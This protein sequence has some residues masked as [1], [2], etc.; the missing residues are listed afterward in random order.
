MVS[1]TSAS[2][3]REQKMR[4]QKEEI[5]IHQPTPTACTHATR[6]GEDGCMT[7][8]INPRYRSDQFWM[9]TDEEEGKGRAGGKAR[10]TRWAIVQSQTRHTWHLG[11]GGLMHNISSAGNLFIFRSGSQH[12]VYSKS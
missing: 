7:N 2:D 10:A 11:L 12:V 6:E 4:K 5:N 9:K 8:L 1:P 3:R